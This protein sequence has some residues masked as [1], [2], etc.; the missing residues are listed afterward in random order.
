MLPCASDPAILFLP[1]LA[2]SAAA[3]AKGTR[4]DL[5]AGPFAL[6]PAEDAAAFAEPHAAVTC[7]WRPHANK[8]RWVKELVATFWRQDR[9]RG[10][11]LTA[12]ATAG[13]ERLP[14]E[15]TL[16]RL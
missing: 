15:A 12:L 13:D 3:C 5:R 10:L 9:L 11:E 4:H 14:T 7:D 1:T 6:F 16:K 2:Q 8:R